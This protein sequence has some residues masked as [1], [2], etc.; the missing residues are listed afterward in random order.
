MEH[1]HFVLHVLPQDKTRKRREEEL[2]LTVSSNQSFDALT[3]ALPESVHHEE[4]Q[5]EDEEGRDAADDEPH[6]AGHRVKQAVSVCSGGGNQDELRP[7]SQGK[8]GRKTALA[9]LLVPGSRQVNLQHSLGSLRKCWQPCGRSHSAA[10]HI[11][12]SPS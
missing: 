9:G 5:R 10:T 7:E 1:E 11:S 8:R 4:Q 12:G 3:S 6:A 2:R